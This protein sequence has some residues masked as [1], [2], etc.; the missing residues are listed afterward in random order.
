MLGVKQGQHIETPFRRPIVMSPAT[1]HNHD[2]IIETLREWDAIHE[3][4]IV[5]DLG[6]FNHLG[7][8]MKREFGCVVRHTGEI[9]LDDEWQFGAWFAD[10][11]CAFNILEHVFNPLAVL[12]KGMSILKPGGKLYAA[13]PRRPSWMRSEHHFHEFDDYRWDWLVTRAGLRIERHASFRMRNEG[14][15]VLRPAVRLLCEREHVYQLGASE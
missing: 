6:P 12:R 4:E 8:R 2:R 3:N 1:A 11:V 15:G 7:T 5:M 9:D 14:F 10:A 13:V